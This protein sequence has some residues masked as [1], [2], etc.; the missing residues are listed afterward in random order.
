MT[1]NL[2]VAPGGVEPFELHRTGPAILSSP[3]VELMPGEPG[4]ILHGAPDIASEAG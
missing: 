2:V 4:V 1:K 3:D